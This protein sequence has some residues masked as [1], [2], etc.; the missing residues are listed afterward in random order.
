MFDDTRKRINRWEKRVEEL[1]IELAQAQAEGDEDRAI[2]LHL[3]LEE[4][5]AEVRYA[6]ADDELEQLGL[7]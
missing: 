1:E 3:D 2:D 6:W 7:R 5:K 4:A